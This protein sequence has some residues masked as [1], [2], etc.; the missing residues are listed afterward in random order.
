MPSLDWT[1]DDLIGVAKEVET[2][3]DS[4]LLQAIEIGRQVRVRARGISADPAPMLPAEGRRYWCN[5]LSYRTSHGWDAVVLVTGDTGDGKSTLAMRMAQE[6]DPSFTLAARLCYTAAELLEIY[7]I[8]RPGQ[9]VLFDEGVRG[10]LAG[11][12]ATKEQK[13]LIQALALVREKGAILFI[14]A[15]SIWNLAKQVRQ[16]RAYMW[17]HVQSRGVARVH[18]RVKRLFYTQSPE[19]GF[20]ISRLCPFLQWSKYS[21]Q[22]AFFREYRTVKTQ[23]LDQYLQETIDLLKASRSKK[24]S[25]TPTV[26]SPVTENVQLQERVLEMLK[27]GSSYGEIMRAIPGLNWRFIQAVSHKQRIVAEHETVPLSLKDDEA[28][29][30]MLRR[31]ASYKDV[32][33]VF[34]TNS[35]H[36]AK[37]KRAAGME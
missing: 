1:M 6:I 12:Q 32:C 37:L 5:V 28:I 13:A 18:E 20:D 29:V 11:D 33:K 30:K 26:P 34:H 35:H 21:A 15:P 4:K 2:D 10:L 16:N 27:T 8:I 25:G 31:G 22:S 24:R 17:I 7:K 14:C 19:L 9:A 23:H 36:I 3:I